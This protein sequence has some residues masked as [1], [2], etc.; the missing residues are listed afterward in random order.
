M[1]R[2]ES[3]DLPELWVAGH[4]RPIDLLSQGNG[5]GVGV[6]DCVA[7]LDVS[8]G[9]GPG[10]VSLYD[11]DRKL[12][13]GSDDLLGGLKP[14]LSLDDVGNLTEVDDRKPALSPGALAGA[15]DPLD[16]RS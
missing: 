12:V 6:G 10:A 3:L 7:C 9:K 1:D 13:D 16:R 8:S 4:H 5:K 11:A 14:L 15:E 2:S